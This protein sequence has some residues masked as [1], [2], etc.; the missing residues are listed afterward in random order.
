MNLQKGNP[1]I[2]KVFYGNPFT[3]FICMMD[4]KLLKNDKCLRWRIEYNYFWGEDE[5]MKGSVLESKIISAYLLLLST[6][7][8]WL[9]LPEWQKKLK[10][11]K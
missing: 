4:Q 2:M 1:L 9:L 7:F 3:T 6:S 11:L 8:N 5:Q 10:K